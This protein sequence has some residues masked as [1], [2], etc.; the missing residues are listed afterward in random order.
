VIVDPS[1]AHAAGWSPRFESLDEGLVGVWEEW[2][3]ADI[4][5][6]AT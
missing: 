6:P 5:A 3:K 4:A 1:Q 2:S